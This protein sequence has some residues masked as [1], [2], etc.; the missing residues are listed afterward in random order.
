[1]TRIRWDFARLCA[2]AAALLLASTIG[3]ANAGELKGRVVALADGDSFTL[4]TDDNKEVRVRLVDIDAPEGG[5]SW[6]PRAK[7]ALSALVS[8]K[9][10][11]VVTSGK[12]EYGRTLGRVYVAGK[13][14]NAEM[15]RNGSA[16]AYRQY[17]TDTSLLQVENEARDARRGLWSLP[18]QETVP[19]WEWRRNE[20]WR[21]AVSPIV[22]SPPAGQQCRAKRYCREM[23]SCAEAR[24]YMNAC[25][26][27]RLD[28]DSDGTPCENICR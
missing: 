12:D 1:M 20:G 15:V 19:P 8:S 25:G 28:G 7:Q 21:P 3:F 18:L 10:V 11:R 24:F 23:S 13:D 14:V 17:L 4:R 16:W 2:V 22:D 5:Q 9:P 6:G 26:V 27:R